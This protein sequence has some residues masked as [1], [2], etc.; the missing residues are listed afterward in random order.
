MKTDGVLWDAVFDHVNRFS[1]FQELEVENIQDDVKDDRLSIDNMLN[2]DGPVPEWW[3]GRLRE[4][5]D[6]GKPWCVVGHDD[7]ADVRMTRDQINAHK[8]SFRC[9]DDSSSVSSEEYWCAMHDDDFSNEENDS[10]VDQ[11]EELKS[12][13]DFQ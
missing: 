5:K 2:E 1:I 3:S 11:E 12:D 4:R 9:E 13:Q 10:D 8:E 7:Y 6:W